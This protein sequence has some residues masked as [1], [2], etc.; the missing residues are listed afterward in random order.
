MI[1]VIRRTATAVAALALIGGAGV[2]VAGAAT[3]EASGT[4]HAEVTSGVRDWFDSDCQWGSGFDWHYYSYCD[5]N[6]WHGS[7]FG[8]FQS[9]DRDHRG[10]DYGWHR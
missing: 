7:H 2:G 9:W 1:N 3:P 8:D 5:S 4:M 6:Y 10:Y